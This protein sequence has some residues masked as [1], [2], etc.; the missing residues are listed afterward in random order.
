MAHAFWPTE[1][2]D[3][4]SGIPALPGRHVARQRLLHRLAFRDDVRLALVRGGAGFGKTALLA[5]SARALAANGVP[6]I[7]HGTERTAGDCSS[8]WASVAGRLRA[9]GVWSAD[10][11]ANA[12]ADAVVARILRTPGPLLLAV[13]DADALPSAVT[14]DLARLL[15]RHTGLRIVVASREATMLEEP[16]IAA[17]H[18]PHRIGAAEL[19]FTVEETVAVAA[20]R[21]LGVEQATAIHQATA[22]WPLGVR[23]AVLESGAQHHPSSAQDVVRRLA[24]HARRLMADLPAD[25]LATALRL[26]VAATA[27][28]SLASFLTD[29]EEVADRM[30]RLEARGLGVWEATDDGLEFRLQPAARDVLLQELHRRSPALLET[31]R[32]RYALWLEEHDRLVDALTEYG[33]L[34]DYGMMADLAGRRIAQLSLPG[35]AAATREVL[36]GVPGTALSRFPALAGLRGL[37]LMAGRSSTAQVRAFTALSGDDADP[38]SAPAP[39]DSYW[40]LFAQHVAAR[41]GGRHDAAATTADRLLE[42]LDGALAPR[43]DE[44][45]EGLAAGCASAATAF[46]VVGR[47]EDA[48][49]ALDR[50]DPSSDICHRHLAADLALVHALRGD[51]VESAR[52]CERA[53]AADD[54]ELA[55]DVRRDVGRQVA[56]AILLTNAADADAALAVLDRIRPADDPGELWPFLLWARGVATLIAR[57]PAAAVESFAADLVRY[58]RRDTSAYACG[59]LGALHANLL[60]AA[61]H[62]RQAQSAL[63]DLPDTDSVAVARARAALGRA[64]L[65]TARHE[66][67]AVAWSAQAVPV[68]RLQALTVLALAASRSEENETAIDAVS[69]AAA[70]AE[71]HGLAWPW[72]LAPRRELCALLE[73]SAAH[74]PGVLARMPERFTQVAA[75]ARLTARETSVLHALQYTASLN[76]IART[77]HVSL[78]TV[79]S[80]L[81]S[82]YRKLGARS[83]AQALST[84]ARNGMLS[85]GP[86]GQ[87]A[88]SAAPGTAPE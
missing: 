52:A 84:A 6:A 64:E 66:A 54:G 1:Q 46:L 75:P 77:Q 28:V 32:R 56:E 24:P 13:D 47:H 38:A 7:W 12:D 53:R 63:A 51:L 8:F 10:A 74:R 88:T 37:L 70:V 72:A 68:D 35:Q 45:G 3:A 21:G 23:L 65:S 61:G 42:M 71:A 9:T 25:V 43:A 49:A 87:T 62:A 40:T 83:R 50:I 18:M 82:V 86:V 16:S 48:L 44:L 30:A 59:V 39:S 26:S 79:R 29:D 34:A 17:R 20:P 2:A 11:A 31:T 22:G 19:A 80:Q 4:G 67:E 57:P 14:V 60:L 41:L 81:R 55:R 33:R 58:R 5:A 76:E 85:E 15:D 78:N 69:R 27:R 36:A 73:A